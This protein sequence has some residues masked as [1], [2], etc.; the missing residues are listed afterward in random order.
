MRAGPE[1]GRGRR[2]G[3]DER[4]LPPSG[5]INGAALRAGRRGEQRAKAGSAAAMQVPVFT[6][7]AF[8]NRP[9]CGNP[10]AVCLLENVSLKKKRTDLQ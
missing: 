7:D 10:A 8:T 1:A 3:S 2:L 9:F 6:V 4:L 5:R